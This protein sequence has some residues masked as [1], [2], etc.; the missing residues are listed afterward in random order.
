MLVP[1]FSLPQF[2]IYYY[3]SAWGCEGYLVEIKYLLHTICAESLVFYISSLKR[4]NV[5]WY[6]WGGVTIDAWGTFFL[7]CIVL[8][9]SYFPYAYRSFLC[10]SP[11]YVVGDQSVL[12]WFLF[13][14]GFEVLWCFVVMIFSLVWV[15]YW[16]AL[17]ELFC[18]ILWFIFLVISLRGSILIELAS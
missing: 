15:L 18:R 7:N 2:L 9:W 13:V 10:I 3:L 16:L 14:K 12:F 1:G 4:F 17:H 6:F 5:I 8:Q 11:V